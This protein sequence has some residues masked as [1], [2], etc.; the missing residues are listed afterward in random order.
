MSDSSK[1]TEDAKWICNHLKTVFERSGS[2]QV[3][4]AFTKTAKK[5]GV[6]PY[7][8]PYI[9]GIVKIYWMMGVR[10][11]IN[12]FQSLEESG[13]I[14]LSFGK[15]DHPCLDNKKGKAARQRDLTK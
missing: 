6:P 9:R 7:L 10:E 3:A 2:S 14:N 13:A 5:S 12:M 8:A 4:K 1:G 11:A 15:E